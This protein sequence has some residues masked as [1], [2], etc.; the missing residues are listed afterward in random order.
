M[1][2]G[3]TREPFA[4]LT[5]PN[6]TAEETARAA[7]RA[8]M[9][10]GAGCDAV[11][12]ETPDGRLAYVSFAASALEAAGSK[13]LAPDADEVH[14]YEGAQRLERG[15]Y[16]WRGVIPG[17]TAGFA[18]SRFRL[19]AARLGVLSLDI[20]VVGGLAYATNLGT[21]TAEFEVRFEGSTSQPYRLE[22]GATVR[23]EPNA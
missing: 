17:R 3:E 10:D 5:L 7:A 16:I 23:V 11:V 20:A 21:E 13:R 14:C 9:L 4:V 18:E 8:T 22:P 15:A 2:R 19:A 1:R 12:L 6:A